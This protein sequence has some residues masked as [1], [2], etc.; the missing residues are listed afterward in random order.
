[1][2]ARVSA[3]DRGFL[4]GDGVFDTLAIHDGIPAFLNAHIARLVRHAGSIAIAVEPGLIG[5][6]IE[7]SIRDFYG[8]DYILRTTLTRGVAACGLWSVDR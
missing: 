2:S 7:K 6:A 3:E 1:M 5:I 4:L 8:Q